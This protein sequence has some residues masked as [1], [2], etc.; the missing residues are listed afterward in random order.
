M[1]DKLGTDRLNSRASSARP[2]NGMPS[3]DNPYVFNGDFVDRGKKSMEV[4]LILLACVVVNPHEVYLNRGNHE[5]P[6]MNT[7]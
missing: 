2:Q 1:V 5:D 3:I 7:R 6:M 4:L